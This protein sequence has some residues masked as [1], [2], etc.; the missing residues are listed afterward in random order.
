[1]R[2]VASN[3]AIYLYSSQ[4]LD[5]KWAQAT[6]EWEEVGKYENP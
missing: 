4:Y 3:G 6:V 2:A 5:A 1:M